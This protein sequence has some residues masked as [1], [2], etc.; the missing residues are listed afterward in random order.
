MNVARSNCAHDDE[1]TWSKMI[2]QIRRAIRH[3]GLNCKIYMDLAG[4]KI[5]TQIIGKGAHKGK[6]KIK[7]G[8][9]IWLA[10]DIT[11]FTEEDIVISPNEKGIIPML[12][13]GV[14]IDDGIIKCGILNYSK[15]SCCYRIVRISSLKQQIKADKGINFPDSNISVPSLT[16]FDKSC[17]PF[18]CNHADLVGYSFVRYA[19][20]LKRCKRN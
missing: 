14:F 5:R 2:Q 8:E 1:P 3:T 16:E 11:G 18:I 12:K 7:E 17:L 15:Q 20:D 4:P 9:L 10:E 19:S 13:K 6:V